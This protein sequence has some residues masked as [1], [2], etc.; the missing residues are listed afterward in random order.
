MK[1]AL[2]RLGAQPRGGTPQE[3]ADHIQRE[4]AKWKPIVAALNLKSD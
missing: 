2:A 4:M 3:L 1:D